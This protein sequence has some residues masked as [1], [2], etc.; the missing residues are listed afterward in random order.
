MES[1]Y[2]RRKLGIFMVTRIKV[3][4]GNEKPLLRA[5]QDYG[6]AWNDYSEYESYKDT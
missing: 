5:D 1:V 6:N 3:E 4:M 2:S